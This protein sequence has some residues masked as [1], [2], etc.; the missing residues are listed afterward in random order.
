MF[1][2]QNQYAIEF[3]IMGVLFYLLMRIHSWNELVGFAVFLR[4]MLVYFIHPMEVNKWIIF[5]VVVIFQ[6]QSL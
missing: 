4:E 2:Q 6:L 5:D 1:V 3:I